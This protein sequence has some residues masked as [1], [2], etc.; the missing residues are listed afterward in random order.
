[1]IPAKLPQ[2]VAESQ[3]ALARRFRRDRDTPRFRATSHCARA[4][5]R[6]APKVELVHGHGHTRLAERGTAYGNGVG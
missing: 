1:M 4:S 2:N 6:L 3:G 5:Q